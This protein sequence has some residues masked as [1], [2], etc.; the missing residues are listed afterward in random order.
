MRL[1]LVTRYTRLRK[2]LTEEK[3]QIEDRLKAINAALE[4]STK[5]APAKPE[6]K[7]K[8]PR[9]SKAARARISAAQKARWAKLKA[10]RR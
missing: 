3:A 7:R 6:K 5:L 8:K 4:G 1:D 10:A 2:T 9:F